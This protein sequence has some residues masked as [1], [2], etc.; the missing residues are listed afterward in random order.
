[1]RIATGG[2]HTECSTG[3]PLIQTEADFTV[4]EGADLPDAMGLLPDPEVTLLGLLHARSVPGGPVAAATYRAFRDRFL[5]QLSAV[6]PVDGVLLLMHGAV[7]VEGMQDAEGDWIGAVRALIGP[8]VPLAVAYDL[9]GNVTQP[10][11]DAID[12]FAAYRT[13]PHEDVTETRN[14]ARTLLVDHLKGGPRPMVGWTPVPVLLP[15]ERSSTRV[16]PAAGIYARLPEEDRGAGVLDA[17]MMVGY[18]WADTPRATA[19]AVVTGTDPAAMQAAS[20]RLAGAW[21]E[22]RDSFGFDVTTAPLSECLDLAMA[23]TTGP[24]ILADSGDNPT[25]GGVGDRADVLAAMLARG[26]TGAVFAGIADAPTSL[27]AHAAGAGAVI[28]VRIGNAFGSDG[29]VV[30]AQAEVLAVLGQPEA[31]SVEALLRIDGL[32]VIVT[33]RRRPFHDLKD[34]RRFGLEP[35]ELPMLVVKSGYLSPDLSPLAAPALMALT[36]GAVNQDIES[37]PNRLRPV[38][39]WPFQRQFDWQPYFRLSARAEMTVNRQELPYGQI[40]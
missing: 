20:D 21:W 30:T 39:S 34:F 14:R 36:E 32:R 17:N 29:P 3:N 27:A 40:D 5:T 12:I 31:R 28:P 35:A 1:M 4:L 16:A 33:Q 38:P 7:H 13:A 9:H 19:C 18:V 8:E 11:L 2:L 6:L 22:A 23:V 37:L 24:V 26:L 10:I 15:G 25:G